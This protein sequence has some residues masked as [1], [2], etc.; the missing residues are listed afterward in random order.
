M[1]TPALFKK[2]KTAKD[3]ASAKPKELEA[4]IRSTGFF[5]AKARSIKGLGER[6]TIEFG[7][8]V[9]NTLAELVTLP[10]VGR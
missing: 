8:K 2:Y 10:G 1:V 4:I 3:F 9:P 7:G 6:L 5:R